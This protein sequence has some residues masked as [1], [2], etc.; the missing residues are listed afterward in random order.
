MEGNMKVAVMEGIGKM[1]YTQ[2][3]IPKPTAREVLV[4]LEYVG[5]CGELTKAYKEG[6][7]K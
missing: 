2:R 6:R 1:G 3:P 7:V 5:I 4:K